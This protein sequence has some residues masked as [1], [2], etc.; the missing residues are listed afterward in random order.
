M[1]D[2][3]LAFVNF[4]KFHMPSCG[5]CKVLR[6]VECAIRGEELYH[7]FSTAPE[8]VC[9]LLSAVFNYHA[10]VVISER[11][12]EEIPHDVVEKYELAK[13]AIRDTQSDAAM[14]CFVAFSDF[15]HKYVVAVATQNSDYFRA[16]PEESTNATVRAV[17][18]YYHACQT[19]VFPGFMHD[20]TKPVFTKNLPSFCAR[21]PN[22]VPAFLR[23]PTDPLLILYGTASVLLSV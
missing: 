19:D 3:T 5:D 10:W 17:C 11:D 4:L 18:S 23:A 9:K 2:T 13:N 20:R 6:R 1:L 22:D 8:H 7:T 12:H 14:N 16:L 21:V 15:A